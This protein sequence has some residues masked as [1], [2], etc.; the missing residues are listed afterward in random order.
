MGTER[1]QARHLSFNSLFACWLLFFVMISCGPA[2]AQPAIDGRVCFTAGERTAQKEPG[3]D[4]IVRT[5]VCTCT[6]DPDTLGAVNYWE[7]EVDTIDE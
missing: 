6:P 4:G 7:C 5:W 3:Y 1:Q 2:F